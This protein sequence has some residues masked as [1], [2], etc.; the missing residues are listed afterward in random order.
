MLNP[1]TTGGGY[2]TMSCI[3]DSD[4][5][6]IELCCPSKTGGGTDIEGELDV[7]VVSETELGG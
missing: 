6:G 1:G 3:D 2:F 4:S 7:I 5:G